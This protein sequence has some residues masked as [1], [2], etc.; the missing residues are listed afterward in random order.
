MKWRFVLRQKC[1]LG[2]WKAL[3]EISL[4]HINIYRPAQDL[5]EQW[6]RRRLKELFR[7]LFNLRSFQQGHPPHLGHFIF[8]RTFHALSTW[9][10]R[11]RH[12]LWQA[13]TPGFAICRAGLEK[14]KF[15]LLQA[16]IELKNP[17]AVHSSYNPVPSIYFSFS[18]MLTLMALNKQTNKKK[19]KKA[20]KKE[21]KKAKI[22]AVKTEI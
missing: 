6:R 15:S 19:E 16:E 9:D 13:Q 21:R 11:V 12:A 20:R 14:P 1:P 22:A 4:I 18:L 10:K 8:R 2:H 3:S 5:S 7:G 17:P